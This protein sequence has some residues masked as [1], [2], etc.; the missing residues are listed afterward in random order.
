MATSRRRER[1]RQL[2]E[3]LTRDHTLNGGILFG[4]DGYVIEVPARA[5]LWRSTSWLDVTNVSDMALRRVPLASCQCYPLPSKSM[6]R[7]S[8]PVP[9]TATSLLPIPSQINPTIY[10]I[11]G[12]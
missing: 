5:R 11:D 8:H 10:S 4:L 9:S 7:R 3:L 1:E 6:E 2:R 12:V